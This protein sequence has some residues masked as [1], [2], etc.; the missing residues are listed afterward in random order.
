[1]TRVAL[2]LW[3]LTACWTASTGRRRASTVATAGL[4]R[5]STSSSTSSSTPRSRWRSPGATARW[6]WRSRRSLL[7]ASFYVNAASWMYLAALLEQRN[8]GAAAR[9]ETTAVTMPPGLIGGAETVAF[10]AAF[11]A[12]ARVS[13]RGCLQR[14][15]RSCWSTSSSVC[16]G[17]G[18]TSD[19]ARDQ[20][21]P[22]WRCTS[23]PFSNRVEAR[24]PPSRS[25]GGFVSGSRRLRVDGRRDRG[26]S[27]A[28]APWTDLIVSTAESRRPEPATSRLR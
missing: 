17:R 25:Y 15:P 14:W 19:P 2:G 20:D 28:T 3:F 18:G 4:A 8:D 16:S 9:G 6:R 23:W 5:T 7:V 12:L 13:A 11:L 24:L 1:M 10:Y 22:T 27:V 26:V 21:T